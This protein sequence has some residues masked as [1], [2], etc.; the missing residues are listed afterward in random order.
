MAMTRRK[1]IQKIA[2]AG[3][4]MG[5]GLWWLVKKA[6]PRRFVRAGGFKKYPGPVRPLPGDYKQSKWSG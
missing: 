5:A 1:F 2:Y 6:S 3:L 4:A